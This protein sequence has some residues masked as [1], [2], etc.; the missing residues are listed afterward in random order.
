MFLSEGP[1]GLCIKTHAGFSLAQESCVIV[2]IFNQMTLK[3]KFT[4]SKWTQFL[5]FGLLLQHFLMN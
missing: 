3:I 2:A 5:K 4:A 1:L